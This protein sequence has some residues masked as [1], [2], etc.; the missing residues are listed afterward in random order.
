MASLPRRASDQVEAYNAAA[1]RILWWC[2]KGRLL[3]LVSGDRF[4]CVAEA[5]TSAAIR[6]WVPR[7]SAVQEDFANAT[8]VRYL[9][10]GAIL[11][12]RFLVA[13]PPGVCVRE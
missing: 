10:A 4:T 7:G 5:N 12:S 6:C 3:S 8:S 2:D 13:G 1:G 11:D 9:A